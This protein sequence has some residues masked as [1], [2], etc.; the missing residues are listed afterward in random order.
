M[1]PVRATSAILLFALARGTV[2]DGVQDRIEISQDADR[3][4]VVVDHA[5]GI[6]GTV[7]NAPES[8]WPPLVLVRLR[9]FSEL[10]GFSAVSRAAKLECALNRPEL[11]PPAQACRLDGVDVEALRR[12]PDFFEVRLPS[13]LLARDGGPIALRWVDQWR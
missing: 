11:R 4:I 3:L 9:G 7:V 8:A 13:A 5:K 12:G 6:G 10:E 2:A 1:A